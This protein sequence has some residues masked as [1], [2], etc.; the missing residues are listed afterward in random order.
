MSKQ[1]LDPDQTQHFVRP[2]LG[3]SSGSVGRV[4]DWV[5]EGLL[6]QATLL[7]ES[8]CSV[9]EQDTLSAA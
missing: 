3:Q 4:L 9:F 5:I 7:A 8:L 6:V 2:D 1:V